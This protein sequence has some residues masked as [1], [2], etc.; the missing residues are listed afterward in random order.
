MSSSNLK[1]ALIQEINLTEARH[2]LR[3][4]GIDPA[5]IERINRWVTTGRLQPRGHDHN[6]HNLYH[7]DDLLLLHKAR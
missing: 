4:Y 2:I 5:P 6:G 7:L 1:V 3:R